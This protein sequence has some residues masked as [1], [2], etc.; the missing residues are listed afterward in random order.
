MPDT[1]LFGEWTPDLPDRKNAALEA[2][3]VISIA[4]YYAPMK[5]LSDYNGASGATAGT[6]LGLKGVYNS[7]GDGQ[8][9]AGDATKLYQL[10]SRVATDVSKG[11]GY[12]VAPEAWWQ[13]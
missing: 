5:Q 6:C 13:P 11:G 2:K 12:G 10:V 4:G 9:F 3:G 8:V 7:A 1:I